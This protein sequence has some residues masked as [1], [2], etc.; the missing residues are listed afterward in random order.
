MPDLSVT[1][2]GLEMKNPYIVGSGPISTDLNNL[3]SARAEKIMKR[4]AGSGWAG[5]VL[6][7]ATK[8]QALERSGPYLWSPHNKLLPDSLQNLGPWETR[9][10]EKNLKKNII[11]AKK[12]GLTVIA[13]VLGTSHDEWASLCQS[14][15]ECGADAVELNVSCPHSGHGL[16][17]I[18]QEPS[19]LEEVLRS[20]KK[21]CSIPVIAKLPSI[22][23]DIA[24]VA[25][26]AERAGA[27]AIAAINTV[28]GMVG[29]DIETG[30]PIHHDISN[31]A[32]YSGISG[33]SIKPIGLG[34]VAQMAATVSIPISGIGGI[35]DWKDAVEFIMAGATTVQICT[36]VMM[37]GFGLGNN[38]VKG[39]SEFMNKKG[40]RRIEDFRRISLKF[41]RT[42]M[43]EME[44]RSKA[45]SYID[46]TKC[47][48]CQMCVTACADSVV[49]AIKMKGKLAIVDEGICVGCGLCGVVCPASAVSF[50][51]K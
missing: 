32:R 16:P 34:C 46:P 20:A 44:R 49:E 28:P 24:A 21:E 42:R 18:G 3:S 22:I 25:R 33:P 4:I 7:S 8:Y 31:N 1:Y 27:D 35:R 11:I 5:I 43:E 48:G 45:V 12:A 50:R 15:E 38:L 9:I 6:K 2:A 37:R 14:V 10:S 51:K 26:A 13:N 40:Y 17:L 47:T 19:F 30:I 23:V 29:I 39:L 36:E 41:I